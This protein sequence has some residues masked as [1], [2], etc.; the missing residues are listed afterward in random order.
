[1][2]G[3]EAF[4]FW[5]S[6]KQCGK[7][8]L[9]FNRL[10]ILFNLIFEA[11]MMVGKQEAAATWWFFVH[12]KAFLS[13]SNQRERDCVMNRISFHW[14]VGTLSWN[15]SRVERCRGVSCVRISFV[16]AKFFNRGLLFLGFNFSRR[17]HEISSNARGCT[18]E[19]CIT[20]RRH[21]VV[22]SFV[23]QNAFVWSSY[24]LSKVLAW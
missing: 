14:T 3:L 7:Q 13:F 24:Q 2:E 17:L 18:A 16:A 23:H 8:F 20:I 15:N 6:H 5:S 12:T 22:G 1:M 19:T 10:L 9:Y 11:E 21:I 4:I